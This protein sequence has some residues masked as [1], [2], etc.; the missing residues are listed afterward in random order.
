M[1][2]LTWHFTVEEMQCKCGCGVTPPESFMR[3]LEDLRT[4]VDFPFRVTSG[5][6]CETYDKSIG[7]AGVHPI[8]AVD[9]NLWGHQVWKLVQVATA[10]D[11]TGIG[12]Q[13][14]GDYLTRFVHIDRLSKHTHPRPWIWTYK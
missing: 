7:G 3:E 9:I 13:Q 4:I 5:F 2:N 12:L 1:T 14:R 8:G 11:W 10:R 6:R